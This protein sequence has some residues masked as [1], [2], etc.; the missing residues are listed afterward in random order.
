MQYRLV[1][2]ALDF[3][4]PIRLPGNIYLGGAAEHAGRIDMKDAL[5]PL[6]AF[7]RVFAVRQRV[8]QTHTLQRL[9]A[10]LERDLLSATSRAGVT[11]TYDF[12]V[13]LRLQAQLTAMRT[14]DAPTGIVEHARLSH[15]QQEL[16]RAAYGEIAALQRTAE[17][18][19]PAP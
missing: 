9:L 16:L 2:N 18:E 17:Y 10:L 4:P 6:V 12:L 13:G 3:R 7:A 11:D 14:G 8:Y 5:Q 1:R 19:F 15:T